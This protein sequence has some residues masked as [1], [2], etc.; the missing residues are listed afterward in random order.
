[1]DAVPAFRH[2]AAFGQKSGEGLFNATAT[3]YESPANRAIVQQ[4]QGRPHIS[5]SRTTMTI[6]NAK[7][8]VGTTTFA[9]HGPIA[10]IAG[11][12]QLESRQHAFDMAGSLKEL[13]ER[14]GI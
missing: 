13:A 3:S 6:L 9:N 2:A 7:V 12:C 11:P 5:P 1:M 8:T 10:L 14:L 4:E